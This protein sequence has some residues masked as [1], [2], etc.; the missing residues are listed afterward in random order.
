MYA[1][2]ATCFYVLLLI[3]R[4]MSVSYVVDTD[5]CR[6]IDPNPLMPDVMKVFDRLQ[7]KPC[8]TEAP[9]THVEYNETMGQYE[10]KI[11]ETTFKR[12]LSTDLELMVP[13]P[14]KLMCCYKA[15][16]R[17]SENLY[18]LS[19]CTK[20]ER[21]VLLDNNSDS[22]IVKCWAKGKLIYTNGHATVPERKQIR[23]RLNNWKKKGGQIDGQRAP[24]VLM[25]GIDTVSR[26]NLKRAMP[27]TYE[28]LQSSGWFELAGYN[29]VRKDVGARLERL[30]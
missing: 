28:Y 15:V 4:L 23:Q 21:N 10:L 11:N 3:P 24:S 17:S 18:E 9:L 29:K 22:F 7:Y 14:A 25:I 13:K 19:Q 30:L 26:L 20:F 12:Y 5:N 1:S 2:G 27:K 16:E 8:T 6:I